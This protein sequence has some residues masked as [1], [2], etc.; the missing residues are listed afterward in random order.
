MNIVEIK[1][2]PINELTVLA[3]ELNVPGASGM[4]RQDLI[5]AILQ[6]QAEKNGAIHGEGVLE[7]L[8][9]GFGFLRAVD[10]NYLPGP[11][12]IYVSPSQ[13]RRFNLRTGDTV[14]GEIRPPK[15]GEKYFALLKVDSVNFEGTE[16]ARDKILFDNL[17]PLYPDQ[18]LKLESDPENFSTRVM[19]IFV[20][21]GK[22]QRALV[23]SPPRAGK[24]VLLKDIAHSIVANHPEVT[25]MVLLIDER[26]EEVTDME[27]SVKGEVISSTFDEPA[28]RHVQVAEMVIEKAK[29]LVEHRRDVVILLDSITRLARAYNTV[30]PPSGKV[31]SGGVD[32]NALHKPKRFFGAA[33]NIE[34][35]GSLTIIATA[36]ID[37]GSRMDEVIF[38]EFKGTGNMEIIL[39]RRIADR[40][41]FPAFDLIRSGTRKEEL[42]TPKEILNRV[43]ILRRLLQEMNPVDAIEFIIDKM[44]KTQ[45]NEEF[46]A[47]MNQ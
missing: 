36:L 20:P 1:R 31:L 3:K 29:R 43:W 17:T 19:D 7:T 14:S 47:S 11:D 38:E 39:D 4:R 33:R 40:R 2:K 24:T 30:V 21:I 42:L 13:I 12:D 5:F 37:T 26:P 41:V 35:G 25:L 46:F 8:P 9:D 32:S 18:K 15:E 23:V 28:T 6:T 44:R 45:T 22:G 34:H 27:R 10:Y 16:Q